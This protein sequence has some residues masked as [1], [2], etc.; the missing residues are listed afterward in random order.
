MAKKSAIV[1]E[2]IPVVPETESAPVETISPVE[3]E[4][5]PAPEE[6]IDAETTDPTLPAEEEPK[7]EI[8]EMHINKLHDLRFKDDAGF[9]YRLEDYKGIGTYWLVQV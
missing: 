1:E 9:V 2:L 7:A 4:T 3:P 6:K 5:E 8:L